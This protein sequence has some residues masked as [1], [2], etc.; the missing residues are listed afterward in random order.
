MHFFISSSSLHNNNNNNNMLPASKD[1][2]HQTY[3]DTDQ[4][5][6]PMMIRINKKGCGP[7]KII[8][9]RRERA[10]QFANTIN[11]PPVIYGSAGK[12]VVKSNVPSAAAATQ[13]SDN[14]ASLGVKVDDEEGVSCC[15][16]CSSSCG[17]RTMGGV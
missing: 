17:K 13:L 14:M 11:V 5:R 7:P 4:S 1:R 6:A 15:S 12:P 8:R 9:D 16:K 2:I 3:H 10:V